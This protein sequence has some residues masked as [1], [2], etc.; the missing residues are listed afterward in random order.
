MQ[1]S[2]KISEEHNKPT[3]FTINPKKEIDNRET[4]IPE[5]V[6]DVVKNDPLIFK[7]IA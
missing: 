1:S 6:E 4:F 5:L 2:I 7:M 3:V